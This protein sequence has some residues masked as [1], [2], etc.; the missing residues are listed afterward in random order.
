MVKVV[1]DGNL[2]NWL[3]QYCFGRILAE[4]LVYRLEAP[5]IPGMSG[6]RD[7][8]RGADYSDREPLVLRGQKPDLSFLEAPDRPQ[9]LLLTGYFQR[10]EYYLPHRNRI[11]EWL[12]V[13]DNIPSD[14]TSDDVVVSI[15]RG[16]DYIPRY[17][18]PLSYY[19]DALSSIS[20]DRVFVCTNEPD[21]PFV[22]KFSR[23]HS[24]VV[25]AGSFQRGEIGPAYLSGALDNLM[26]IRK[27]NKI[28]MSNS[29]FAWWAA[30][31]SDAAEVIGPRPA[32]GM[33]SATD[34][35]S[36]NMNLE[37]P[38]QRY[39]FLDCE[40]YRSVFLR[41]RIQNRLAHSAVEAKRRVARLFPFLRRRSSQA[42]PAFVFHDDRTE[43]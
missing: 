30:F 36:R 37:V 7:T 29:S 31:L 24:A 39:R 22:K 4:R 42:K 9:F 10:Y 26:F 8:V 1:Y 41:E 21:D 13:E 34:P 20:H 15:R 14:V 18:L 11:R 28:V 43:A 3:F 2:G 27:F 35:I 32:S 40:A 5:P 16:R 33:W 38:E 6:T 19:E 25:R 23:R 12:S 17:G